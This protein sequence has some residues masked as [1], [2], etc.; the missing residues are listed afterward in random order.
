[1]PFLIS[2]L[3]L[4]GEGVI[5]IGTIYGAPKCASGTHF[6]VS[7]S[8]QQ[9]HTLVKSLRWLRRPQIILAPVT[10][11]P[12]SLTTLL[13]IYLP[14]HADLLIPHTQHAHSHLRAFEFAVLSAWN[15]PS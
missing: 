4:V 5:I 9:L 1:M 10:P 8:S 7:Q 15:G 6:L 3:Y 13:K 2:L 12:S 14:G 11:V